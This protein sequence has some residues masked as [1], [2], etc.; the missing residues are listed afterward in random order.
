M[1]DVNTE[2]PFNPITIVRQDDEN[3]TFTITNP[4]GEDVLA[5]YYQYAAETTGDF[6]CYSV[7]PFSSCPEP[8]EVTAHCLTAPKHSLAVVDIWFVDR[9]VLDR[10]DNFT[11]P[12]C[13]EPD[14]DVISTPTV[15][16]SF[17]VYCESKCVQAITEGGQRALAGDSM[18]RTTKTATEFE[19][20]ARDE[21]ILVDGLLE[22]KKQEE[23]K[24]KIHGHFC[25]SLD[26]PCGENND[27][28]VHVCHYSS[29]EGYQTYCVPESDS[30]VIA[31]VPK[32]YCGPCVG[33]Y[34]VDSMAYR[35]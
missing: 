34:G 31:Y 18:S 16:Y 9:T 11:V 32:D 12:D 28:M 3:V 26:Y 21:G 23:M 5:V 14:D 15:Q 30:D 20:L 1:S 25:S 24:E 35:N 6:K 33:G 17:K 19:L 22:M 7:V 2:Y 13:C 10:S 27:N 8:I 4:F 29:R